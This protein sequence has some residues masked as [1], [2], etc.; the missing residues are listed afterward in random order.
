MKRILLPCVAGAIMLLAT[1]VVFQTPLQIGSPLSAQTR[2]LAQ[3]DPAL[4]L[5]DRFESSAA[6][7]LPAVVSVE[8]IKPSKLNGGK[9]KPVEESGSGVV[10]KSD[11]KAGYFVITNNHVV[12]QSRNEQI[13][14]TLT[15]GRI[16]RPVTVTADPESD[17]AIMSIESASRCRPRPWA[18]ATTPRWA[19]GCWRSAAPS[20]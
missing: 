19:D 16:F 2:P 12:G 6:K 5:S 8:A 3:G 13:T 18:T 1:G 14:I 11:V 15:D 17:L 7:V 9:G 10:V 4:Q 20:V